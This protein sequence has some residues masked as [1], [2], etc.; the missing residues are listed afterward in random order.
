[1][2]TSSTAAQATD[3]RAVWAPRVFFPGLALLVLGTLLV[4]LGVLAPGALL[5]GVVVL[6]IALVLLAAGGIL[7]ALT[8]D[9]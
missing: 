8:P 3:P 9:A 4:V 7:R 5:P 1:M 2:S 6:D